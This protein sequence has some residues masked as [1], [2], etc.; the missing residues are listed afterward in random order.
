MQYICDV[1]CLACTKN[2]QKAVRK[3][4]EKIEIDKQQN[5][6]YALSQSSNGLIVIRDFM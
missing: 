5:A 2:K 4:I 6:E 1:S 3:W